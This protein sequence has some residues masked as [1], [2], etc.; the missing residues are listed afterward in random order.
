MDTRQP[1]PEEGITDVFTDLGFPPEEA[2][3]LNIKTILL[4]NL[5]MAMKGS[6]LTQKQIAERIGADQPKVSMLMKGDGM[7]FSIERI[8]NYLMKFGHH[9][10][11]GTEPSFSGRGEVI[12]HN[13]QFFQQA[14]A[15]EN[16][17][18]EKAMAETATGKRGAGKTSAHKN[19]SG[20]TS[21]TKTSRKK[22]VTKSAAKSG[23]SKTVSRKTVAH[24]SVAKTAA[25]QSRG[26]R[27]TVS[28]PRVAKAVTRKTAR[29]KKK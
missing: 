4:M 7:S 25:T 10:I 24:K 11:I 1:R 16:A 13:S 29:T 12:L 9:V 26:L 6:G 5:E 17:A 3:K 21:S 14:I 22:P 23:G 18:F 19:A 28:K 27:N 8:A 15:R 2:A 20:R